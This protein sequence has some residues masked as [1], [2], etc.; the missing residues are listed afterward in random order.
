MRDVTYEQFRQ[1]YI[2]GNDPPRCSVFS[3]DFIA[4]GILQMIAATTSENDSNEF[5][6]ANREWLTLNIRTLVET[7]A[8]LRSKSYNACLNPT[9]NPS[10]V[11]GAQADSEYG[12]LLVRAPQHGHR[13]PEE[14]EVLEQLVNGERVF[15]NMTQSTYDQ[16]L[17]L[18]E[19][20]K[21]IYLK[22]VERVVELLKN[23]V[24]PTRQQ[25]VA[26]PVVD[27]EP[28]VAKPSAPPAPTPP[29]RS[30]STST[31]PASAPQP[32][33]GGGSGYVPQ[34]RPSRPSRPKSGG[35]FS[36]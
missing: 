15:A 28:V 3:L 5:K 29:A 34:R 23:P 17:S 12:P 10:V 2:V 11:E 35:D 14:V 24:G 19:Y 27:V 20:N 1:T 6:Y 7:D 26:L 25:W 9:L 21:S 32:R 18:D 22:V 36:P 13:L 16:I 30:R 8:Q 4:L 33:S 31:P